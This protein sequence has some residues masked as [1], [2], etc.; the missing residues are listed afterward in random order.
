MLSLSTSFETFRNQLKF[1][2]LFIIPFVLLYVVQNDSFI[3]P[4]VGL[5]PNSNRNVLNFLRQIFYVY[6]TQFFFCNKNKH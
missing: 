3:L 2:V 6:V 5:I 4:L 1:Q